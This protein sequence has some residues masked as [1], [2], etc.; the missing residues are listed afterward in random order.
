MIICGIFLLSSPEKFSEMRYNF[1]A[2]KVEIDMTY[3][4]IYLCN[5]IDVRSTRR[6]AL[7][8]QFNISANALDIKAVHSRKYRYLHCQEFIYNKK[9]EIYLY[10][11]KQF[12]LFV[13]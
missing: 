10:V 12:W 4:I 3:L 8:L 13:I 11:P 9:T 1:L 6:H 7:H 2:I 5:S